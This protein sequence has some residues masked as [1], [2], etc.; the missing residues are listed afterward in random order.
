M[1]GE[2]A[3]AYLLENRGAALEGLAGPN[4]AGGCLLPKNQKPALAGAARWVGH[5]PEHLGD[6]GSIPGQG[7][8]LSLRLDSR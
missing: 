4:W 5:C 2:G 7:T 3:G 6:A 1:R 8:C